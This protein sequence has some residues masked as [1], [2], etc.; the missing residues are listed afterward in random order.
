MYSGCLN[1]QLLTYKSEWTPETNTNTQE[2]QQYLNSN[3]NKNQYLINIIQT[4]VLYFKL[5]SEDDDDF[6]RSLWLSVVS[7]LC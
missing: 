1:V 7:D 3:N 6:T 2:C 4:Y 5:R